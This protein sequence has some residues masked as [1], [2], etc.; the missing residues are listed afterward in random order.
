ML[1][2]TLYLY[3][4]L[5]YF[6]DL[7]LRPKVF[8]VCSYWGGF[9]WLHVFFIMFLTLAISVCK[10]V[11]L[12]SHV[13]E[14]WG[15]HCFQLLRHNESDWS[16]CLLL[17]SVKLDSSSSNTMTNS[18]N[19][20]LLNAGYDLFVNTYLVIFTQLWHLGVQLL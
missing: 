2:T 8:C 9:Q 18:S 17:L 4:L 16:E 7:H 19:E 3:F 12:P 13:F 1:D 10:S 14:S 20:A 6:L 11:L 5:C 15:F